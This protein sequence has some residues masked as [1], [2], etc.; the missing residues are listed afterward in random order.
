[1]GQLFIPF[2]SCACSLAGN[3]KLGNLVFILSDDRPALL[4][5]LDAIAAA[6]S[7]ANAV[8]DRPLLINLYSA[9][10]FG[11][12]L[13][14][15]NKM[16]GAPL[17]APQFATNSSRSTLPPQKATRAPGRSGTPS[18]RPHSVP[19]ARRSSLSSLAASTSP[20][21]GLS[22]LDRSRQVLKVIARTSTGDRRLRG[23][24]PF[25]PGGTSSTALARS[26]CRQSRMSSGLELLRKGYELKETSTPG[27]FCFILN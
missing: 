6:I 15:S 17:I 11:S 12:E 3:R 2:L 1:M 22:C 18:T 8:N 4:R 27:S 21:S 24:P 20:G 25:A 26:R 10:V 5:C 23:P 16:H 19:S 7:R 13:A 14:D 9:I